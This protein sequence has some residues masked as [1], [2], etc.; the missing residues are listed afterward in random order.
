[1]NRFA[2]FATAVLLAIALTSAATTYAQED[3][4]TP[5]VSSIAITSDPDARNDG[6][7]ELAG[8]Q[9]SRWPRG[10]Y[11]IGDEITITVTFSENIIVTGTPTIQLWVGTTSKPAIFQTAND[12]AATFAYTVAEGDSDTNGLSIPI[13][14]ISLADGTIKDSNDN[15][16]VL[17][18]MG[19]ARAT[20]HKVDGIRPRIQ[21]LEVIALWRSGHDLVFD[22]GEEVFVRATFTEF[23]VGSIAGPPLL[24]LDMD[25]TLHGAEWEETAFPGYPLF[26]YFVQEGDWD[27]DG[28]AIPANAADMNGGFIKDGAGNDLVLENS[29]VTSTWKVDGIRPTVSS[30]AMTSDPGDD[31]TYGVGDDIEVTVT[32]SELVWALATNTIQINIGGME[33]TAESTTQQTTSNDV[34]FTYTVQANDNDSDGIEIEAN[35]LT[36]PRGV[37]KDAVSDWPGGNHADLKHS[38]VPPN[39]AHKVATTGNTPTPTPTPTPQNNPATGQPSITGT[40]QATQTLTARTPSISDTD[41]LNNATFGY[42]WVRNDGNADADIPGATSS[43]YTLTSADVGSTIRVKVSFTDDAGN[44][45]ALTSNPTDTVVA[46]PNNPATGVPTITGATRVGQTLTAVTTGISDQDGL[47]QVAYTYQWIRNDGTNDANISGATSVS[48]VLASADLGKTVKVK[49]SFVDDNGNNEVVTSNATATIAADVNNPATGLPTITGTPQVEETLTAVTTGISDQDGL[50]QAVYSYQWIRND[51]TDD[52]DIAGATNATYLLT[53]DDQTKFI[54]VRVTFTDDAQNTEALTSM[55]TTAVAAPDTFLTGL[56]INPGTL[57]PDFSGSTATYTVPDIANTNDEITLVTTLEEGHTPIFVRAD[58]AFRVC[59]IYGESCEPWTYHDEDNNQVQ[60]ISDANTDVDGFQVTVAVGDNKLLIHVPSGSS[61]D[62]EFYHLT[63]TRAEGEPRTINTPATGAPSISGTAQVGETLTADTSGISDADGLTSVSYSYQWLAGDTAIQGATNSTYTLADADESKTIKVKVSF[64]DDEGNDETLTSAATATVEAAPNSPAMGAPTIVGIAQVDQ[65]LTVGTSGIADNDGLD[66]A[67]FAYQWITNDGTIDTDIAGATGATYT[68]VSED[69]GKTIRVQ[70]SFTDDT[71]NKERL[72]SAPTAAVSAAPPPPPDNVRAVTQKSG[73]VELTWEAPDGATVTGYRIERRPADEDRRDNHTLV[74]DTG[75]SET[76]YTDES[77]EKGVEYEYRVSARNEDGAGEASGWVSSAPEEE[78]LTSKDVA[79][80]SATMT[81]EWVYQGYGYYSTHAKK[82]GSLS[83]ASFEVGGTT[84]TVK[85]VETQGWWTYIGVDRE[86]PFGFVLELDGVRFASNDA[87]FASYS[88]GNIYRWE[89]TGLSLRDGDTVEVRLLRAF[90]DETAVNSAATGTPTISGTVQVGETLT[91]DTSGISDADGLDN[92]AFSYQWLAGDT[93]VAGA[94]GSTY[95]LVEA[96][97]SKAIKVQVSFTDDAGNDETLTSAATDAVAARPNSLATGAP[98]ISGTVQVGETLTADTSG[99][100]DADGLS[101]VQYEYQWLADDAEIAGATSSTYTLVAA[102]EGK[103]VKVRVSFTDD[104]GNDESL[105]S[106]A[107]ATVVAA[108]PANNP[109]TGAP[110]I[111]GAVQVGETLTADT[112]GIAD[113]NGLENVTYSYKWLADD[114]AIAGATDST[115]TLADADEGKAIKVEVSFTDDAGHDETLTSAATDAVAAAPTPNSP[116]TGAPTISGT[117][118]VGETLTANTSGIADADGLEKVTLSYQWLAGDSDI[119]GATG[120]TYAM[121]DADEGKA[122]KVR[123]SFTDDAGNDETLTSE[124]TDPVAAATQPNS[125][126]TGAPTISG[127]VQVGK[128]L[129]ADTSGIADA[130]GLEKVTFSYQ[131]LAGDD[132]IAGATGSTYTLADAD[133]GKAIKVRVSFTDDG[134][135]DE[136]LTSAAT[137]GVAGNKESLTSKDVAVWS[138]VMTVEWVHQGYGYYSTDTK[139]AGSLSPASFE[140]DGTAYTVR[141]VETQGWWT[142]IGVDRELPFGF[143]LELDGTRLASNDASFSSYSY[144]NIYRWEGTGLSLRDGD[145]V[146]VRILRAFEDETAVNSAATGAPTISGTAQVGETLT[147]DTSG[148]ADE[149]GLDN[150]SFSYRW[151]AEGTDISGATGSTHTLADADEGKTIAVE[152][153]FTDDEG[154]EETLTSAATDPVAE[155]TQPNSPATGAPSISGTAQVGETLTADSSG[156]ADADGLTNATLSYQWLA[157]DADI[158]GATG[159]TYTLADADEGM[160]IKLQ[161]SFTDDAGNDETLTSAATAVVSAATQPNNPATGAPTVS[162]TAQVGETLTADTSG[163]A[164]EDGLDNAAFSYQW[165]AGDT[166][167]AGATGS[168]YTLVEA[169][170]SKAIKV[171]VSFTDDAGNPESLTSTATVAVAAATQPNSPATGAPT[172]SGTVQ[173]GETLTV[174]TSGIADEDGLENVSFSYQW[175]ADNAGIAGATGSTYTLVEADE[176]KAIKVQVSFTDDAGHDETLTSEAIAAVAAAPPENNEA[177]GAPSISGTAQVGETLTANTSGVIDADG[178]NNVQYDYQWLADA[179]EIAGATNAD[180]TLADAD[181]GQ[182][183]KVRVS[184]SDDAGNNETLTSAPTAAVAAPAQADSEDEPSE[185]SYLTVVVTEDDSDPDNVFTTFTITWN[186]AEDCSA[187][188]NAY[189]DGVVGDPIH[190]GYAASEGEQIAASLTNVSAEFIG[191]DAKLYCGTIGSGRLVDSLWIPEYSRSFDTV[192]ISRAY[193]PKP[194][195]YSTEPGLTALTVSSGTLTPAFHSHTLNYTVPDVANAD[196]RITLTTTTKADYYTVAFIPG[197]L[198]FYSFVCSYGGQ[199]SGLGYQDDT[200]NPLYP[201]TDADANTPGFQMELDEGENVFKIRVWPNCENGHVYKLTVTRAANTPA[202]GQ[203]TISGTAQ[204]GQT[205]TADT[206]GISDADGLTNAT[207][208]YQ[209]LSSRD[210]EIQGATGAAYTLVPG[211][212]GKTIKVRVSFTDDA[213]NQEMLTS[214]ATGAVAPRPNSPAT[215]APTI[216]GAAQVGEKL[217]AD[218]SGIADADGLANAGFT[219]QWLSSR[220]TEIG[221]ATSSTYTLQ[222]SDASKTIK[223]RVSFTDDAG[224]EE[225]L[226][227]PATDAVAAAPTPNSPATKAYI[228]VV[229][230]AGDDTVSWSDPEGCSSDYNIYKAIT[231]SG[232]DSETSHIHLGSAASGSTQATLAISHSEDDRYPAVEVELYCGTYDAASSQNLLI[233]SARLSIGGTSLVGINIREGTYSSAPLTALTISSGMLSPDFDRGGLGLYSA[234]VPS[235]VEVITLDP[236]VLTGYQ[237]DLVKNPGSYTV[238]ICGRP[239]RLNCLYT[240]GDGTT[241]GIVLSDADTDTEGFQIN[242]DRGENR[243]GIGVHKGPVAAGAAKTYPLTVTRAANTPATGQPTISGTAQVGQTLTADTSGIS[244]ADGLTNA[245]FSYQ[246]LSSRDT[247]IGGATSS[248]YTLQASDASKTIKVR[249][250]FTDDAGNGE[251]LTSAATDAVAAAP[252]SN[253]PATGTPTISGTA[254]V[255]DKLTADT[256]GIADADGLSNA[257]FTYQWLVGDTE[258]AGATGSTYTLADTDEGKA[259]KVEVSFTD[260]GGNDET[261]T[262]VATDAVTAPEPP[263]RPTGLTAEVSHDSVTLTWDDP[264]DDSITGYVI[265]R[266][267]KDI[268]EEG[269]FETVESDTGSAGTTYTDDTVEPEKQYVYRIKAI[270]ANGVSEISSWV[271]AD[272]PAAPTPEP[273]AAPTGLAAEV[274][275]NTVT[276]TW[277]DPQDDTITGYVILR[278]NRETDAEGQFTELAPDTGTGTATYTDDTV[279][280]ETPYTYRIKASNEH[281]TSERSR[282]VHVETT[283]APTPEG[284]PEQSVSEGDTDLPN[285]NSTPG[286]VAVGGSATGAIGTPGDQDRFAVELEAGRTYR[287]DLTGSPGG[288]GTLPDT[289]FRAIYNSEGQYQ[290]DSYNDDFE[291]SRDS[292]VTFTPTE[293]GTYYARVSGDRDE[294][295][296]YTLSVTEQ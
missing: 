138:A 127:T 255:G 60:P 71:G 15:D 225:T 151:L 251:S 46:A 175:L 218:P 286:R 111:S 84:Y 136:T 54:K 278:R 65:T 211:D 20:S 181:E 287:F 36:S 161:V 42:Q 200:G 67:D 253:N 122:I 269:T 8:G 249:V 292:R 140:V 143:V 231:P 144:G 280:A 190:L 228:T 234:E 114:D 186:D 120:S 236:T 41:G 119:S 256:S 38:A 76:G 196:G 118:Q 197:S 246:W 2:F 55:A 235:D 73:A 137:E 176:G 204:V 24:N 77:A 11:G 57:T 72:T 182:T 198:Y 94:T 277:D 271:R 293:S 195:T 85:M 243:L 250:S 59:S 82:A 95:T 229:I 267:D 70:V 288:G 32:F 202:T 50:S 238:T 172:T 223:V 263:D 132:A 266:R 260:D 272:T 276:L 52:A 28:I 16:A 23:V 110:A 205:L 68:L 282:W 158:S 275:H 133:E 10:W 39:I 219:Y 115:Q 184:F 213:D 74:E 135:N 116:A 109:A 284:T 69:A 215:G 177:T 128:T 40:A 264:Q 193:L 248:T 56:T 9:D 170:E 183:I 259:I 35:K 106:T 165:L 207:F 273:P 47:T 203:P 217:T 164:D 221:G 12:A 53:A 224:N 44:S 43:T 148:I 244:D 92:A 22:I 189:L 131:W 45:E 295:G 296:S 91:A 180:Y 166:E 179:A 192:P 226:T 31:E 86:L 157:D 163:I 173:V 1:M 145:A 21:D 178:L 78:S 87:S 81:V 37:I 5:T 252:T 188:Y 58:A 134:G 261:L 274:S 101:N 174:D 33:R 7:Y 113:E 141:M 167:V 105:T 222:A 83:P 51:G 233:S 270:N 153:S 232:N 129:T 102:D 209:W 281:G 258:V 294:V 29:A 149:D 62:D 79:D 89:G 3:T 240:Y 254:Q 64:T 283:A 216:G 247:E 98:T 104:A 194:G 227:S 191:F 147:A 124:A 121:A 80:W 159:A 14:Q 139:K 25:G 268:H 75:S 100:A 123:V 112:S 125:P 291:G 49:V 27:A 265:L 171:Q 239:P 168:T 155:A 96:D 187:S 257:T 146:E 279:A 245:T 154:N 199:Q 150:V 48:Y 142:Y 208:S 97:E 26:N 103:V 126:A 201:L 160:A 230:A 206:S 90:E 4:T 241:T 108:V 13:N 210:T 169:D 99:V 185:L 6:L 19:M 262:S 30:I 290:P 66:N 156:V 289:F 17:S 63:I 107:T 237:T 214:A 242:L 212:A 117:A 34:I 18:N 285:D 152:V 61:E 93:E 88:Y 162:G 220:D 130:D